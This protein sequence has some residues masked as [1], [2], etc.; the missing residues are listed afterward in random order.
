MTNYHKGRPWDTRPIDDDRAATGSLLD[1]GNIGKLVWFWSSGNEAVATT[2]EVVSIVR[3]NVH[4]QGYGSRPYSLRVSKTEPGAAHG[5]VNG[6]S[7]GC[8]TA[9]AIAR[10]TVRAEALTA[11][12]RRLDSPGELTL[13]QL[14]AALEALGGKP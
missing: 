14:S 4:L 7:Y 6:F 9:E 2:V 10:R 8:A 11:L 1:P 3:T 5:A 12:R 13:D